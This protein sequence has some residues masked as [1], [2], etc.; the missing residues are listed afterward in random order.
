MSIIRVKG[1]YIEFN[2]PPASSKAKYTVTIY[3]RNG[4]HVKT[5]KFGARG[6]QQY[7]DI[8]PLKLYANLDHKDPARRANY[9][10]RHSKILTAK[11]S[12]AYLDP[13][14]PAYY[15]YHFLW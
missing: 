5:L 3:D 14:Q 9:R 8:T 13:L 12:P 11:G 1:Y 7:A 4:D 2:T 10:A 15:S 6:Y